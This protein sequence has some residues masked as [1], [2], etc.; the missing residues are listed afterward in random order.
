MK[1]ILL[2]VDNEAGTKDLLDYAGKMAS[3]YN[4][5]LY[6]LHIARPEPEF[7]GFDVGPE[8]IRLDAAREYRDEHRWVQNLAKQLD[9]RNIDARA[10][11][12]QGYVAEEILKQADNIE[13]ELV[14]CGSH[15][16]G[17]FYN[18]FMEST[19]IELSKKSKRPLLIY[20]M[21]E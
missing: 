7:V 15:K 4:A 16:N 2:A 3:L 1:K 12:I 21:P 17:F 8:Y 9:S 5:T 18:L 20:P 6:I 13:A 11:L 10:L 14:I 19:A